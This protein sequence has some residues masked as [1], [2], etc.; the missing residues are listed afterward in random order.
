MMS[1][2]RAKWAGSCSRARLRNSMCSSRPIR[3]LAFQ[4]NVDALPIA[5]VVLQAKSNRLSEFRPL[6]QALLSALNSVQKGRVTVVARPASGEPISLV[7]LI[8]AVSALGLAF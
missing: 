3:N 5:V 7:A 2:L 1:R 8:A 6:V 4:Q